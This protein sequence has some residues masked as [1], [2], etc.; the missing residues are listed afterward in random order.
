MIAGDLGHF[1]KGR[2]YK[3]Y[4]QFYKKKIHQHG[5]VN[6]TMHLSLFAMY[7]QRQ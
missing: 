4:S 5:Q 1:G 2:P 6:N 3:E 7:F